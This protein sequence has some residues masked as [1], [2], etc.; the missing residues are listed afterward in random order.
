M[1]RNRM[2]CTLLSAAV[3]CACLWLAGCGQQGEGAQSVTLDPRIAEFLSLDSQQASTLANGIQN[4]DVTTKGNDFTLHVIQTLG[5][6][7]ELYILYDVTFADNVELPALDE[8]WPDPQTGDFQSADG[9][10]AE[11]HGA[12]NEVISLEGRTLTYLAYVNWEDDTFP[13]G[14]MIFSVGDFSNDE[15]PTVPTVTLTKETL[16]ASWTPTNQGTLLQRDMTDPDGKNVGTMILSSYSVSFQLTEALQIPD[17]EEGWKTHIC[18]LL[19]DQGKEVYKHAASG[20]G[21]YWSTSFGMYVDL[22]KLATVQLGEY[23][24]SLDEGTT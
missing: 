9:Q 11:H 4:V 24:A 17:T 19:D 15:D 18:C 7:R 8:S 5:N 10:R 21:A 20:G 13:K 16:E 12:G 6:Q 22:S 1:K 23:T 14:E 2:I 3:L